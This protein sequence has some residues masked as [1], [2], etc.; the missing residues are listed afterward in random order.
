MD[1]DNSEH[2]RESISRASYFVGQQEKDYD[3]NYSQEFQFKSHVPINRSVEELFAEDE[4]SAELYKDIRQIDEEIETQGLPE[5]D[6]PVIVENWAEAELEAQLIKNIERSKYTM[7][8]K[9]Q[10]HVIPLV[11]HGFDIKAQAETG[12]GKTCA[13]LIPIINMIMQKKAKNE[14][15]SRRSYPI[16]LIIEPTREI[17]IQI[18]EQAKK[19]AHRMFVVVVDLLDFFRFRDWSFGRQSIR[20]VSNSGQHA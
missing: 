1:L 4:K 8:R 3:R 12:S 17:T 14:I 5:H 6:V 19:L 10:S 15:E 20:T 13:F 7:P 16:C 11:L 2:A 9:I 18:Y